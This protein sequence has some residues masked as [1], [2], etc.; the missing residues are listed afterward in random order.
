MF[1]RVFLAPVFGALLFST[2]FSH[3][4]SLTFNQTSV[5]ATLNDIVTID[6]LMDFTDE[7]TL[8][9]GTDIFFDP[10]VLSFQSFDFGST[11]LTL[12][13]AFSRVPDLLPGELEGMAF[14]EFGGLAG[15]GVVATLTFQAIGLGNSALTME[16]TSE[17]LKGGDFVS[18]VN[19]LP[20]VVDFGTANVNVGTA[21]VPIPAALWLFGSGLVGLAGIAKKR[22]TA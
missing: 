3:A 2:T 8:G 21:V 13:P 19:F 20:M 14:G 18:D 4:A 6:I 12:D 15:P 5:N 10:T 9:G 7:P 1:A 22:K 11:T 16:V 17:A